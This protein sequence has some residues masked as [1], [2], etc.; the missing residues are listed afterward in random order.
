MLAQPMPIY[1]HSVM[2]V[3]CGTLLGGSCCFTP[4]G[5]TE[6]SGSSCSICEVVGAERRDAK[7]SSMLTLQF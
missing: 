1:C 7:N 6:G 2:G 5:N 3:W 4:A